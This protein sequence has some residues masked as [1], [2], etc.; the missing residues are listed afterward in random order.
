MTDDCT[1]TPFEMQ[2]LESVGKARY[3][4]AVSHNCNP[5][6][7]PSRID[8]SPTNHIR[9]ARTEFSGSII[10]NLYWRPTVG[11]LHANDIGGIIQVRSTVLPHGRL[12]VKPDDK[13]VPFMLLFQDE[14]NEAYFKALGWCHAQR[15]K[16]FPLITKFGDPAH[17]VPQGQLRPIEEL[18]KLI[19]RSCP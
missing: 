17:F 8:H 3:S 5:G 18:R 4:F 12:I 2:M 14:N 10:M 1:L 13:D 7:G 16:T 19:G 15:A 6:L 11:E 9:G